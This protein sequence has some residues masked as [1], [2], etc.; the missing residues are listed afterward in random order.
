MKKSKAQL[1]MESFFD[2]KV[3]S[4]KVDKMLARNPNLVH[5][6]ND[7]KLGLGNKLTNINQ[8]MGKEMHLRS[9]LSTSYHN[10]S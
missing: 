1:T 5:F 7:I 4:Y 9:P 10:Y 8:G 6:E 3:S 2:R